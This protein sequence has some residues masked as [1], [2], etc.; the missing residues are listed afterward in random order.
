[1]YFKEYKLKKNC[2]MSEA[3]TWFGVC[4]IKR[5]HISLNNVPFRKE[6]KTS[7][8]SIDSNTQALCCSKIKKKIY[9]VR[10]R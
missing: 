2:S 8:Q 9:C 5:A 7:M 1:M 4:H 3:I 10:V 6:F